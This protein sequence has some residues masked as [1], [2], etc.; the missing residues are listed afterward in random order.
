MCRVSKDDAHVFDLNR[1][2]NIK[3][4]QV[5]ARPSETLIQQRVTWDLVNIPRAPNIRVINTVRTCLKIKNSASGDV[6]SRNATRS[7]LIHFWTVQ[8]F[9]V[10][11]TGGTPLNFTVLTQTGAVIRE[12]GVFVAYCVS[13]LRRH[14]LYENKQG[15]TEG[16]VT[17]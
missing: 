17:C 13:S 2:H 9:N 5:N 6:R 4:F 11:V 7:R 10:S 3:L 12:K 16:T 14:S 15:Y 8:R 1:M